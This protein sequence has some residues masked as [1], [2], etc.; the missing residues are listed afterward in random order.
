MLPYDG[1]PGGNAL[2]MQFDEE[3]QRFYQQMTE[4][5]LEGTEAPRTPLQFITFG[6]GV[7]VFLFVFLYGTVG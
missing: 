3:R 4:A 6:I 5:S 1:S 7:G 2:G